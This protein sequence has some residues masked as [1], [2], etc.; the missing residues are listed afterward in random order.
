[1]I[2]LLSKAATAAV[3]AAAI[4]AAAEAVISA[5]PYTTRPLVFITFEL[6]RMRSDWRVQLLF[7]YQRR[8][9]SPGVLPVET[10]LRS[11]E[12]KTHKRKVVKVILCSF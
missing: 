11:S 10:R 6:V 12:L 3:A 7:E 4:V 1:M 2:E 5:A 9:N 8:F